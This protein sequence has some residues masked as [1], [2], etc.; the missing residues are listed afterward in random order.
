M[1]AGVLDT[2]LGDA[3]ENNSCKKLSLFKQNVY[4]K[5]LFQKICRAASTYLLELNFRVTFFLE[6]FKIVRLSE[7]LMVTCIAIVKMHTQH[8]HPSFRCSKSIVKTL[9]PGK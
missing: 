6:I 8:S 9:E 7:L 2:S 4:Y 3:D 5:D 1:F